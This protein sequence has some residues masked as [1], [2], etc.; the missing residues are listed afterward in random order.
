MP[1]V[2]AIDGPAGAGKSTVA[3]R[4]AAALGLTYLDTGAMYRA[5]AW[6]ARRE[7]VAPTDETALADLARNLHIE[8]SPLAPDG[9]QTVI[10]DGEDVTQ[11]IREPEISNLT[12]AISALPAVRRVMVEQ[13]RRIGRAQARGVVLE[14]RDIG[15]VVFPDADVKVFLTASPEERARRRYEELKARRPDVDYPQILAEQIERDTRDSHRADSPLTVAPDAVVV[16]TDGL[17]ID[18]VTARL[19]AL[20]RAK[21]RP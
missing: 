1:F 17:T 5:P 18:E 16:P 12:S 11:A 14:G 21:L 19:L 9:T 2:V 20:C 6:K 8:F 4:V 13:Q 7:G 10:V 3:R 15:T